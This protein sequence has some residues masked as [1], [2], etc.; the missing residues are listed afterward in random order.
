MLNHGAM[1]IYIEI[2]PLKQKER[3]QFGSNKQRTIPY[4]LFKLS[5]I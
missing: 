3:L 4:Y 1:Q 5:S 2:T